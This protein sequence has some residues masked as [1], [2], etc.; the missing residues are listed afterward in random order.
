MRFTGDREDITQ[1]AIYAVVSLLKDIKKPVKTGE[2]TI[3]YTIEEEE[4]K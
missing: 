1:E 2:Y 4:K 3:T